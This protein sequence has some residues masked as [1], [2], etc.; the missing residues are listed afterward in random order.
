MNLKDIDISKL[1]VE[2]KIVLHLANQG[3]I[4]SVGDVT[5]ALKEQPYADHLITGDGLSDD[6]GGSGGDG[7][8]CDCEA[9]TNDEIQ[10][11]FDNDEEKSSNNK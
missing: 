10:I 5:R 6:V 11:V 4:T 8:D 3:Y 2:Q 1:S 9:L 7:D